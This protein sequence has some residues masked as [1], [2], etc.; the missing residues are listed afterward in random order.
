MLY[1]LSYAHHR[2]EPVCHARG[3]TPKLDFP[4]L[5][6]HLRSK[7]RAPGRAALCR[8]PPEGRAVYTNRPEALV[9]GQKEEEWRARRDSNP[10]PPA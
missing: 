10:R 9:G 5:L 2:L 4:R 1:Q 6:N 7:C 8:L 3:R